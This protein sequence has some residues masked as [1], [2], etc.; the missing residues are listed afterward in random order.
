MIF[1]SASSAGAESSSAR[2]RFASVSVERSVGRLRTA[3]LPS[4]RL[5]WFGRV[6]SRE[7][8][9]GFNARALLDEDFEILP[10]TLEET[11]ASR[12]A[13]T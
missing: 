3:L 12:R 4:R 8:L 2:A 11:V 13:V 7:N 9:A 1:F 10:V 6:D 5:A